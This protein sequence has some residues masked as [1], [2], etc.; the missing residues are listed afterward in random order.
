MVF[1][2][3]GFCYEGYTLDSRHVRSLRVRLPFYGAALTTLVLS[4]LKGETFG[5][6][7]AALKRVHHATSTHALFSK[8]DGKQELLIVVGQYDIPS[9]LKSAT[10]TRKQGSGDPADNR[11]IDSKHISR[12][13]MKLLSQTNTEAELTAFLALRAKRVK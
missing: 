9:S 2:G 7:T 5:T 4:T 6:Y 3:W 8:Y 11:I 13:P 10:Q 12:V 1:G